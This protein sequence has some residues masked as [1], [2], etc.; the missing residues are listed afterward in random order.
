MQ[1]D[2]HKTTVPIVFAFDDNY[3][4]PASIAIQSL[5]DSKSED[6]KYDIFIIHAGL[7]SKTIK[8]IETITDVNWIKIDNSVFLNA[9][10][11]W[12]GIEAY[13]R[14][15]I[16]DLI[17][18][19]DK[20]IWSDVDVLFKA[21][22]SQI[23]N[24]DIKNYEWMGVY[25][26]KNDSKYGIH[27]RFEENKK[28]FI[29]MNGFMII[30]S[31][32]MREKDMT[33]KFLK[34]IEKFGTRLKMF[35]LDVL[36]LACE[37]IGK[38]PFNYCVLENL[39]HDDIKKAPE[40]LWLCSVYTDE[41]L[42]NAKQNPIIVHYAGGLMKIWLRKY[43]DIPAYYWRYIENSPFYDKDMYFLSIK[44]RLKYILL[45]AMSKLYFI[46]KDRQNLKKS[47]KGIKYRLEL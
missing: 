14:L 38:I 47:I 43:K 46:K 36:N 9:P 18:E 16:H 44:S 23:Y 21:D 28:E 39:Y 8:K 4:L 19:Y 5:L 10:K 30:N 45:V 27:T 37:K 41:E 12:S 1:L 11:G 13:Y 25:A 32:K 33:N 35:E 3:A 7:K 34:T 26:E 29:V 20:I 40:Y 24:S 22:L 2:K 6:T 42:N 17:K 31:K 15:L